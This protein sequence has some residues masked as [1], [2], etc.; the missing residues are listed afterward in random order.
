MLLHRSLEIHGDPRHV[1]R[2]QRFTAG[3]LQGIEDG[4]RLRRLRSELSMQLGI[5]VAVTQRNRVRLAANA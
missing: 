4:A 1:P 2:A 3:L 5:V